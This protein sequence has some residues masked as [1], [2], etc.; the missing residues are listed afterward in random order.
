MAFARNLA[1]SRITEL[2][3]S[4]LSAMI[5]ISKWADTND[6]AEHV[7]DINQWLFD[8]QRTLIKPSGTRFKRQQYYKFLFAEQIE[9]VEDITRCI[10]RGLREYKSL[11]EISAD[12][13]VYEKLNKI[14][15]QLSKDLSNDQFEG[16]ENYL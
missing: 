12:A 16:I 2:G 15:K 6:D 13:E 9:K 11:Q 8:V 3:L 4:V 5:V 10:D 14:Y 7:N 1:E